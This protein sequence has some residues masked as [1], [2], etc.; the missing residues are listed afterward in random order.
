MEAVIPVTTDLLFK[1]ELVCQAKI[2]LF[3]I[4][5]FFVNYGKVKPALN[6][7][8]ELILML[9]DFVL[10]FQASAILLIN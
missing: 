5:T 8:K 7:L 6:A 3:L 10:Q 9:M 2:K 4:A 1:M